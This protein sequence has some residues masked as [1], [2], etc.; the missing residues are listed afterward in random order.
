MNKWVS[1]VTSLAV[2]TALVLS[3]AGCVRARPGE[4]QTESKNVGLDGAQTAKVDISMNSGQLTVRGG[5]DGLMKAGFMYNVASW[6]PI[7]EYDVSNSEGDLKIAQP[8][9]NQ[10]LNIS[11]DDARNEW[12]LNLN[13]EVPLDLTANMGAGVNDL[14]LGSLSLNSLQLNMGAGESTINLDGNYKH[15]FTVTI[16]CGVGDTV[17][18]LPQDVGVRV[19]VHN[20]MGGVSANGFNQHGDAYENDAYGEADSTI[21]VAIEKGI[22]EVTLEMGDRQAG[23]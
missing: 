18:R 16:R 11:G 10:G 9:D 17:V 15:D 7:V 3:V 2:G 21:H 1:S 23:R 22:G 5:A 12:T 14:E 6:K 8:G 4:M 20:G 13:D 19:D